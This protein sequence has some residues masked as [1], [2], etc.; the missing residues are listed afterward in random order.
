MG[1]IFFIA[2]KKFTI[3][4]F[5]LKYGSSEINDLESV[6]GLKIFECAVNN[7]FSSHPHL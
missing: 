4:L 7:F 1:C 6:P 2:G 3:G 5:K